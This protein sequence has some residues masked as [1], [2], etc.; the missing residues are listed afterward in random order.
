MSVVLTFVCLSY[1]SCTSPTWALPTK[2]FV[3]GSECPRFLRHYKHPRLP[4]GVKI[5]C[6]VAGTGEDE[7]NEFPTTC[8][9]SPLGCPNTGRANSRSR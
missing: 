8:A 9:S 3:R 7:R 6:A 1:I 5:R 4:L 2:T